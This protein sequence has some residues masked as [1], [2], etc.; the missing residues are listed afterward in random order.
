MTKANHDLNFSVRAD[1]NKGTA[2]TGIQDVRATCRFLALATYQAIPSANC[3]KPYDRYAVL[4]WLSGSL[5]ISAAE[6]A[7]NFGSLI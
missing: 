1:H 2:D 3:L 5:K 4:I 7:A 6:A